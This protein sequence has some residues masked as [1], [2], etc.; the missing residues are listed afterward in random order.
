MDF[1]VDDFPILP[2][3]KPTD[4]LI[5]DPR[6]DLSDDLFA[7]TSYDHIDVRTTV[8]QILDFPRCFVASD[9]CADFRR[10]PRDEITDVLEP[11]F[12]LDT[13]AYKIDLVPDELAECLR[14][15]VGLLIP[16]VEKRHLTN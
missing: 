8:K 9:N 16:K 2:I 6:D 15:L 3:G 12:P 1:V 4:I 11:R 5:W 14:V 13:Y 7:L 10:Q